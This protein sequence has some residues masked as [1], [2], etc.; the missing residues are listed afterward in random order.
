[1][2]SG[3][4]R[5][6]VLRRLRP[7]PDRSAVGARPAPPT[8]RLRAPRARSRTVPVFT[9]VR[10]TKEEPDYAPAASLRVR[11]SLSPQP[12]W[13]LM[14][15]TT[16]VPCHAHARQVRAASS[17]DPPGSS[18]RRIKGMSHAGSSPTPLRHAR[19]TRTIWQYWPVPALSGLLPPSPAPPGSGCPQLHRPAAT[20]SAAKVSH[21][22]STHSASRRTHDL[23]HTHV[24]WLIAGGAP[25]PHIQARLGQESITTTIDT[26]GHLLPVGDELISRIIDAALTGG[27]IRPMSTP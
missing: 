17:P 18:W 8:H 19:R 2:C 3:S 10:S 9:V 13:Q 25:L 15:T 6:G 4:P 16:G 23:R 24:A 7:A 20:G 27:T 12:P 1:M 14:P 21:L 11:R 5:P 22:P 26:Y